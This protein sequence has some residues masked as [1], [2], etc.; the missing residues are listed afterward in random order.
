[1]NCD[2]ID[3]PMRRILT[4]NGVILFYQI[5]SITYCRLLKIAV[6]NKPHKYSCITLLLSDECIYLVYNNKNA[7]NVYCVY[8]L[9][10]WFVSEC[11][12]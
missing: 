9:V 12:A 4:L 5:E 6:S 10:Q 3:E 8:Q 2:E 7:K 1:M 11:P